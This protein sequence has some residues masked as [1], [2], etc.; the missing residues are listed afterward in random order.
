M[1][2]L[3]PEQVV[4]LVVLAIVVIA[5]ARGLSAGWHRAPGALFPDGQTY[6]QPDAFTEAQA[7]LRQ[8][9]AAATEEFVK[10]TQA[11]SPDLVAAIKAFGDQHFVEKVAHAV[12]P[13]TL[14]GGESVVDVINKMF[15]GTPVAAFLSQFWNGTRTATTD[16]AVRE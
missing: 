2:T 3:L 4:G 16:V 15:M 11:I 10:R 13:L 5:I 7:D 8:Q 9:L 14:L 6:H 1:T 12:A